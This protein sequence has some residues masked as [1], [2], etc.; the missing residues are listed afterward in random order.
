MDPDA[1]V[2]FADVPVN[3]SS[4]AAN[5]IDAAWRHLAN[6]VISEA[7]QLTQ[8]AVDHA[9]LAARRLVAQSPPITR[10]NAPSPATAWTLGATI[11]IVGAVLLIPRVI[12]GRG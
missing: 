1:P 9:A 8:V 2:T 7:H 6:A 4:S 3:G 10:D 5:R 11:G 12:H